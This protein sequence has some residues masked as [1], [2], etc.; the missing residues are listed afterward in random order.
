[1]RACSYEISELTCE[2]D[3]AQATCE[4]GERVVKVN[5]EMTDLWGDLV[6]THNVRMFGVYQ[7]SSSGTH[8]L[9]RA[10]S[11]VCARER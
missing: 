9:S 7:I 11:S 2:S 5:G 3:L 1:M 6:I 8:S 4:D 10:H